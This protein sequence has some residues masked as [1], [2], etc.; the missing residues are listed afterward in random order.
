MCSFYAAETL[1]GDT[2]IRPYL[3]GYSFSAVCAPGGG[4]QPNNFLPV[5][6][7]DALDEC[8]IGG[9][10]DGAIANGMSLALRN[11]LLEFDPS[12]GHSSVNPC[13]YDVIDMKVRAY[14]DGGTG[15]WK[16][17]DCESGISLLTDGSDDGNVSEETEIENIE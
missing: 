5:P 3:G 17:T 10:G 6:N 4:G 9:T 11:Y 7:F 14:V 13:D 1:E 8:M 2:T 12:S 16:G 15:E